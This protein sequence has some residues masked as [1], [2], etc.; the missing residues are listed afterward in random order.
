M[1]KRLDSRLALLR[2]HRVYKRLRQANQFRHN[3]PLRRGDGGQVP[4][5]GHALE[6]V[7][8]TLV[9]LKS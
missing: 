5:T 2:C 4:L 3:P 6:L 9:E 1:Y 8:A 7:S